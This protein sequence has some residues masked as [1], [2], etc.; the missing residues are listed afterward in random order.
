MQFNWFKIHCMVVITAIA[1][2]GAA[3]AGVDTISYQGSLGTVGGTAVQDGV[4]AL[5][6]RL[7][8]VPTGGAALWT[9]SHPGVAVSNGAFAVL[10]GSAG[11][12]A[13]SPVLSANA[14]I[15]LELAADLGS[16]VQTFAPRVELSAS[17]YVIVVK[18]DAVS[19]D[20]T[21]SGL[22]STDAQGALD[23]VEGRVDTLE[24]LIS[25]DQT[26]SEVDYDNL[27]SG[28]AAG[29]VQDAL[30]ELAVEKSEAGHTHPGGDITSQ[31]ASAASAA[32]VPWAGLT[33]VPAGF[34]DGVDDVDGGTAAS[35]PWAGILG[36]P[37]GFADGVDNIDGGTAASVPWAGVTGIPAG[38]ADGVDNVTDGDANPSNELNTGLSFNSASRDLFITD[39]GGTIGQNLGHD[40]SATEITT[41]LLNFLR[42]P[43]GT[44]A[45]QVAEGNHTHSTLTSADGTPPVAIVVDA[46]GDLGIGTGAPAEKLEINGAMKFTGNNAIG[47]Q[48]T[49]VTS[50]AVRVIHSADPVGGC[51]PA[52][53][54][55]AALWGPVS[56]TLTRNA[57]AYITADVIRN[58]AG[59][60]DLFLMVDGTLVDR[61]LTY[62]SVGTWEDAHVVWTGELAAGLHNV[63]VQSPQAGVWGCGGDWGSLDIMIFE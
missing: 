3:V 58:T 51:P 53:A 9:E 32:S 57:T 15:W 35:V 55:D 38:I 50:K 39:A 60:A 27:G 61:T 30:D 37:A 28:L 49:G 36:L 43:V 29:N 7:Y 46:D 48:S 24:G 54:A 21:S 1:L 44:G 52:R 22:A 11:G 19:Y 23:E 63:W 4:Y 62:T 45:S 5:E 14:S 20:N 16:G 10:L 6:F 31:V 25:D 18:A 42:L 56:F 33:G 12:G 26:A 8:N 47:G 13:L 2:T 59:R 41:G 17:P 40:H 34:A